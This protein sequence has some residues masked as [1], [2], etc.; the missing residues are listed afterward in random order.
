M[1]ELTGFDETVKHRPTFLT[2]ICILPFIGSGYYLI[3][4]PFSYVTAPQYV[5]SLKVKKAEALS[6]PSL[7]SK[8]NNKP[9]VK[10]M[11]S[12]A[13][14]GLTVNNVQNSALVTIGSGLLCLIGAILM[15]RLRKAGF[16]LYLIG[17]LLSI[18]G[19]ALIFKD[20]TALLLWPVVLFVI[21]LA[22]VIMYAVNLK[23][24]K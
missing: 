8:K 3:S 7:Q 12:S 18:V 11:V 5:E 14:D 2:V 24:M 1:T 20:Y 9:W 19:T 21:G 10:D 17:T 6:D 13:F 16:Y 15:W 23:Y 22:F 4:G